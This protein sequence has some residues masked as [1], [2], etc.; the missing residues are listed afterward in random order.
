MASSLIRFASVFPVTDTGR[1]LSLFPGD[2]IGFVCPDRQ[3][4]ARLLRYVTGLERPE[5]GHIELFGQSVE[6]GGRDR[7]FSDLSRVGVMETEGGLINNLSVFENIC[8]PA[9]YHDVGSSVEEIRFRAGA[10]L[11]KLGYRG[12]RGSPPGE[13]TALQRRFVALARVLT[14]VPDLVVADAPLAGLE[15]RDRDE[16]AAKI[17]SLLLDAMPET[18]L[19]YLAE[20]ETEVRKLNLPIRNPVSDP[21][22]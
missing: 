12:D 19:L 20:S 10:A 1:E 5:S 6:N 15:A 11:E 9:L 4:R 14:L 17:H 16:L 7:R 22:S 8:L 21:L 18:A 3:R 2:R 13:I